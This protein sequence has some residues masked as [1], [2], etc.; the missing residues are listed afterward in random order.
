MPVFEEGQTRFHLPESRRNEY[1]PHTIFHIS[2]V[3]AQASLLL[4]LSCS[5]LGS[6]RLGARVA[7][8]IKPIT[9]CASL[10]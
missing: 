7:S 1:F 5:K 4:S 6:Q 9:I 3:I 8:T 10:I 2:F